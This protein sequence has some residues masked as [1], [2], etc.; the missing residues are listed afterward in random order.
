[1]YYFVTY[2]KRIA[3]NR[4]SIALSVTDAWNNSTITANGSTIV[5]ERAITNTS[6][7]LYLQ[8]LSW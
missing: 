1:M 6:S 2:V 8:L 4:Q 7:V 3:M 5:S